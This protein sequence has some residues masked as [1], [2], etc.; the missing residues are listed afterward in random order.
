MSPNIDKSEK[1]Y[2]HNFSLCTTS[3]PANHKISSNS[4]AFY[5]VIRVI[6]SKP[7]FLGEHLD[8]LNKSLTLSQIHDLDIEKVKSSIL[9]LLK[10][11]PVIEKNLKLNYFISDN[12]NEFYA[13]FIESHYPHE[14]SYKNGVKVELLP[15]QRKTPNVKLENPVLRGSADKAICMSQTHEVLLVNNEG[16]ITEGSRSNFFA[17]KRN[18]L[19]TPPS[20]EV[21]E[22]ITRKMVIELALNNCINLTERPIHCSEIFDFDGAFITGTS[23]KVLPITRIGDHFYDSIPELSKR[24]MLL[25]DELVNK[26]IE[27]FSI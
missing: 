27:K 5:E 7:L 26:S 21:L 20:N 9:I 22:G 14:N 18:E 25:Y 2:I 10:A 3:S 19:I 4:K 15:M 12:S 6:D 17:I 23:S 1:F 11:N 24:L 16:F 8:R 13:F